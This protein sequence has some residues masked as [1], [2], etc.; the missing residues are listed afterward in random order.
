VSVQRR[1]ARPD[2]L[3]AIPLASHA[4]IEASAGTG[5]TFTLEHLIVDLI[6]RAGARL[7]EILVLTFTEKATLEMRE[8]V[9][10]TLV[11]L[12]HAGPSD[13]RVDPPDPSG[14]ANVWSLDDAALARLSEAVAGFEAASIHTIHGYCQRVLKEHAFRSRGLFEQTLTDTRA[15]FRR[16]VRAVLREA[17]RPQDPAHAVLRAALQQ[18]TPAQLTSTLEQWAAEP[19]VLMP[20][21]SLSLVHAAAGVCAPAPRLHALLA[22]A[23][24]DGARTRGPL[25]EHLEALHA[26]AVQ[27][28]G[29]TDLMDAAAHIATWSARPQGSKPAPQW[30]AERADKNPALSRALAP[31]EVLLGSVPHFPMLVVQTLLPR[32][33]AKAQAGKLAHGEMDFDDLLTRVRDAVTGDAGE[34]LVA[35]L[36]AQHRFAIVDEFQDTDATQWEIFRRLFFDGNERPADVP[37]SARRALYLIG[38]PKQAIYAFRGADVHTYLKARD[39]L[40]P[41]SRR[42]VLTQNFRSTP[43][44]IGAYNAIFARGFFAGPIRYDAPVT[45]GNPGLTAQH[46]DGRPAAPLVLLRP[47]DRSGEKLSADGARDVLSGAIAEEIARLLGDGDA[48]LAVGPAGALRRLQPSDIYVLGR[49]GKDLDGVHDRLAARGIPCAYFKRHG[50]FATREAEDLLM[51]L[52]AVADPSERSHRLKAWLTPFF[53]LQL[54]ELRG[55]ESLHDDHPLVARLVRLRERCEVRDYAGFAR[56][57]LHTSGLARRE[58][59][60]EES[61][62]RLTNYQHLVD[63]LLTRAH[64]RRRTVDELVVDFQQLV[65]G[66][67]G[68]EVGDDIERVATEGS[69]VQLLTMHKSKGLEAEVVFVLGGLG[70]SE[71]PG[72]E[73]RV[74]HVRGTREA[75]MRPLPPAVAA[76]VTR[77]QSEEDERLFY[78]ALTRARSRLYLPFFGGEEAQGAGYGLRPS[79]AYHRVQEALGGLVGRVPGARPAWIELRDVAAGGGVPAAQEPG[80]TVPGAA[81]AES[82]ASSLPKPPAPLDAQRFAELRR[83][84]RGPLATSYSRLVGRRPRTLTEGAPNEEPK[85]DVHDAPSLLSPRAALREGAQSAPTDAPLRAP[86]TLPGGAGTGIFLHEALERADLHYL[87]AVDDPATVLTTAPGGLELR[88]LLGACAARNAV[89][90]EHLDAAAQLLF[91]AVRTPLPT[92]GG[93]ALPLVDATRVVR[94]MSFQFPIPEAWH[95]SLA[96]RARGAAPEGTAPFRVE[97]G[98]VRGVVDVV[99]EHESAIYFLDWK[100]DRVDGD[101]SVLRAHVATHYDLQIK[102]YTLGVLRLLEVWDEAAYERLFGGHLYAFLRPMALGQA[103]VVFE[104]PTFADVQRWERELLGM[105]FGGSLDEPGGGA[106]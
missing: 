44:V 42:V 91:H 52:R 89:G 39:A 17:L 82:P 67:G 37:L 60:V 3:D 64:G 104:R 10:A 55:D 72:S 99:F 12:V 14:S 47:V 93:G 103:G 15:H 24:E 79:A 13:P 30:I 56:E 62:R 40:A 94:E 34:P 11:A 7:D 77:E 92:R 41:Y 88:A 61:A 9:R 38:D 46:V 28:L 98:V 80:A 43:G 70:S 101:P 8:R 36:R 5:K 23:R 54:A 105:T 96:G 48:A 69:A 97:R 29:T 22:A 87:A 16:A 51:V 76:D 84:H 73:P 63:I 102:L 25:A 50:L 95:P 59:F 68:P 57:L 100:S 31:F 6:V 27:V 35:A 83:R 81:P 90:A 78:V 71:R 85:A 53:G 106:R 26:C 33:L 1:F 49:N 32:V 4:W 75:W 2:V 20:P 65:Q 86:V 66:Q 74:R 21:A 45:C 19:G 58:L 18:Q